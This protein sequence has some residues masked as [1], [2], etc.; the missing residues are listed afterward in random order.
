MSTNER[1]WYQFDL[2]FNKKESEA[3]TCGCGSTSGSCHSEAP[4]DGY[5][6][7]FDSTMDRRQAFKGITSSLLLGLGAANSSC[8]V[9]ASDEERELS[10]INWEEQFKGNYKLM[11]EDEKKA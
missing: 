10:R 11:E 3:H 8:S 5:E 6:Q 7:V 9:S 1:E 2:G 4:K